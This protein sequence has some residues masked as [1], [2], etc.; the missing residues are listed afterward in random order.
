MYT[1]F[2]AARRPQESLSIERNIRFGREDRPLVFSIRAEF[3]NIFNRAELQNPVTGNPLA[4]PTRNP[5]GQL[6]G[7]FGVINQVVA[8]G[9]FPTTAALGSA[10]TG[11]T[12]LRWQGTI[13]ARITF[14]TQRHFVFPVLLF[15]CSIVIYVNP[16]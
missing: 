8:A 9:A 15:Q 12:G 13:A 7:G 1:D 14:S 11:Y 5:A 6:I 16:I 4:N 3:T 10:S 2:R